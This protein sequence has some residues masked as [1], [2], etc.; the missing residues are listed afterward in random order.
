MPDTASSPVPGVSILAVPPASVTRAETAEGSFRR[1]STTWMTVMPRSARSS[2]E[3]RRG[4]GVA[5]SVPSSM[6]MTRRAGFVRR[7]LRRVAAAEATRSRS[8]SERRAKRSDRVG[9]MR[10][11]PAC[12]GRR[13]HRRR[14]GQEVEPLPLP[15]RGGGDDG[16]QVHVVRRVQRTDLRGDRAAQAHGVFASPDDRDMAAALEVENRRQALRDAR[17]LHEPGRGALHDGVER[18]HG[19][20][21]GRESHIDGAEVA[22]ADP[23]PQEVGIAG[24]TLPSPRGVRAD[25]DERPGCRIEGE[26]LSEVRLG[27]LAYGRRAAPRGSRGSARAA[28]AAGGRRCRGP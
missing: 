8:S 16:G 6:N 13:V 20:L 11:A 17:E 10:R 4:S 14:V 23:H 12:P 2:A 27:D 28:R 7:P 15:A 22:G 1:S 25:L 26:R 21:L 18:L 3:S 5:A 9:A 19:V 24:P